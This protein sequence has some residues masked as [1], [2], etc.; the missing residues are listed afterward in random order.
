M[1]R[2]LASSTAVPEEELS[3]KEWGHWSGV[4][5]TNNTCTQTCSAPT[6]CSEQR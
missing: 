5:A 4:T 3:H 1:T 6:P 2:L